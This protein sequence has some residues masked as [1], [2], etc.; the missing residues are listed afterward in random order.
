MPTRKKTSAAN[1]DI[2]DLIGKT[3]NIEQA[4]AAMQAMAHPLRLKIL[5][6]VGTEELSVLEIVDAVGTS[7]S[8][9]SQHLAVLRDQNILVAR[10]EAQKVFYRIED[11]RILKMIS[12]TREIFCSS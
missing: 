1:E 8:N 6:L 11:P 3:E 5:C 7:Q 9:I 4:S 12:L 2:F 10:K